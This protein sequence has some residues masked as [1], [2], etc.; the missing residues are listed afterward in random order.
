MSRSGAP[1]FFDNPSFR[2]HLI[3]VVTGTTAALLVVSS[4]VILVPL[5]LRFDGGITSP[6]EMGELTDRILALHATL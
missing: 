6:E 4:A 1:S 3:W 5:F 2:A